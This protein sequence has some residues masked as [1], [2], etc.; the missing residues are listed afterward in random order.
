VSTLLTGALAGLRRAGSCAAC[1]LA[2]AALTA[3]T[4]SARSSSGVA[5]ARSG[6]VPAASAVE[7][8]G[9][10]AEFRFGTAARPFGWSTA[11]GD[12]N[13]DGAPD[14]AVADR[15]APGPEGFGYRL[16]V[17][18]SGLSSRDVA[19][20]S[21]HAALTVR[22]LDVDHDHDVDLVISAVPSGELVAVWLNDGRGRFTEGRV[23][24]LPAVWRSDDTLDSGDPRNGV[25]LSTEAPRRAADALAVVRARAPSPEPRA[26]PPAQPAPRDTRDVS[27]ATGPRAPPL[28][29]LFLLA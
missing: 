19:F 21:R 6:P 28:S 14:L 18:V 16:R 23:S 11:L 10:L 5:P 3:A 7:T 29:T 17:S 2:L 22:A 4:P 20:V 26:V 25:S 12:F 1:W 15:V 8:T 13:A 9:P 24:R 27:P